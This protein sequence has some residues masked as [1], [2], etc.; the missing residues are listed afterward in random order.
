MAGGLNERREKLLEDAKG[1]LKDVKDRVKD[2][3][4]SVQ[5]TVQS[6]G[7][8]AAKLEGLR[9]GLGS[10]VRG[11]KSAVKDVNPFPGPRLPAGWAW[12]RDGDGQPYFY[13]RALDVVTY[14]DPRG[15]VDVATA[16][17]SSSVDSAGSAEGAP[18]HASAHQ[19]A[20]AIRPVLLPAMPEKFSITKIIA[21]TLAEAAT[22]AGTDTSTAARAAPPLATPPPPKPIDLF[23][24][25]PGMAFT[26]SHL[27]TLTPGKA[28]PSSLPNLL[29]LL[30]PT[31]PAATAL[32]S[33]AVPSTAPPASALPSTAPPALVPALT[34][35]LIDME[36]LE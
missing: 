25:T 4:E 22:D 8:H 17:P 5:E 30:A 14:D 7:R 18:A 24:P 9:E 20:P 16:G 3:K 29:D 15:P 1:K 10:V 33:T 13:N 21:D 27:H 26:P 34:A 19:G 35:S 11:V 31:R 28:S 12:A 23:A 32:P 6:G 2:V 36:I